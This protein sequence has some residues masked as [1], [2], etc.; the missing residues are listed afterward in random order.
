MRYL[1]VLVFCLTTH[2]LWGQHTL[3]GK[4][5]ASDYSTLS[6]AT[7]VLQGTDHA[8][9][10]AAD[11]T[12]SISD[13]PSGTYK[14]VAS[15][16][17]FEEAVRNITID[18]DLELSLTLQSIEY[19]LDLVNITANQLYKD[20]PFSFEEL[21]KSSINTK[22][23]G[24]DIPFI[25]EHTPSMVV[26]SDAGA[27]IGYTGMRIR[28]SD[29]TRIN[30]TING[31]PWNDSESQGTFFVNLP[32][33]VSSVESIQIQRGLGASTNGA[34]AF[35]GTVAINTNQTSR[36]AFGAIRTSVGSY[37]TKKI[38]A[39][40]GSGLINNQFSIEGRY[41]IIQSDGYVDRAA[42]DLRS[43]SIS[44]A[45]IGDRSSLRFNLISGDERTYQS[46]WGVPQA[47]VEGNDDALLNHYF[48]N[49]GSIYFDAQDSI[50]LF[51][52]DRRYNYYQYDDQV[53]DYGQDHYQLIY[54]VQA[55]PKLAL[56]ATAHYTKGQG[57]FEEFRFDDDLG[58]YGIAS[59]PTPGG[60]DISTSNLVRR[61]WLDNDF[62]GIISN[63]EYQV[64]QNIKWQSGIA[65]N[66]YKGDHFGRVIQA[67]A[68]PNLSVDAPYY[69]SDATKTDLN[70]YSKATIK[71]GSKVSAYVDMQLR[72][73]GYVSLGNDNDG[74][75]IDVDANYT[76][77][78]PKLGLTYTLPNS[79]SFYFSFARGS[80][81]PVRSDFT[82]ATGSAVPKPET[83]N[84]FELGYRGT[85]G[86]INIEANLFHM[87]YTDQLVVT[88]A[89]NDVGGSVRTN[90]PNSFRQGIELSAGW[91][92]N[93]KMFWQ[94]NLSLSR[95]K[96]NAFND[97]IIDF[98]TFSPVTTL[99]ENTNIA[100]SPSI[101]SGSTLSYMPTNNLKVTWLSK[102]VGK[103]YLDNTQD[104]SKTIGA[105]WVNDLVFNYDLKN[106]FI[107]GTSVRLAVNNVLSHQ[108]S[109]NGYT[110]KFLFGDLFTENFYYP[111]AERNILVGLDLRF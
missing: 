66:E 31:I 90:V 44:A 64:N 22:N 2:F 86:A 7:I 89:I 61:R 19:Q 55:S 75:P 5:T 26:T 54:N 11:G 24:Q 92:I 56:N 14:M 21:D 8:S 25:V 52:S 28:G 71:M 41:S 59:V 88:G 83:L 78:N 58:D 51:T 77:F 76:F 110:Y 84:D 40:A 27:G 49:V 38:T 93:N 91:N 101:V 9:I 109:A 99:L 15:Y 43:Y 32:D 12:Y 48:N 37:N 87:A 33:L 16:L 62:Y 81:E 102:Y 45:K 103:Q 94:S 73:I 13:I 4:I 98:L 107:K 60:T 39:Q 63:A 35:G 34:G 10:T 18:G 70:L 47:R 68:I 3:S 46:W 104:E 105:Y 72:R 95:N 79:N 57:F 74:T 17:G 111:Q 53:D 80:R 65:Y 42:S 36:E 82:D 23:L 29:A 106:K 100:L 108:Y 96:I 97:V 1:S 50:N 30:V 67:D 69:F 6:G 85:H 20:A